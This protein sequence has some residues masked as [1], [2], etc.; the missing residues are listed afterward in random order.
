MNEAKST[1]ALVL[2]NHRT[3]ELFSQILKESTYFPPNQITYLTL[4]EHTYK[5]AISKDYSEDGNPRIIG[6]NLAYI[7]PVLPINFIK[8]P[9]KTLLNYGPT[10][11]LQGKI[12]S[13]T[14]VYSVQYINNIY[15]FY[16]M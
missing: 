10:F 15:D 8:E 7:I 11:A 5:D 6:T 14:F 3:N 16:T 9:S 2:I 1:T 12:T 13:S 4:G